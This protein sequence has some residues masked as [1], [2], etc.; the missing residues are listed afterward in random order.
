MKNDAPAQTIPSGARDRM[1]AS[2]HPIFAEQ[3]LTPIFE[4][5]CRHFF[6]P[7]LAANRAWLTMLVECGIVKSKPAKAIFKGLDEVEAAG[8]DAVRPFDP[9]VEYYYLHMERAL[10]GLVLGGEAVVG[11]LNLGRTRPEPLARMVIRE[12]LLHNVGYMDTEEVEL[13]CILPLFD[14]FTSV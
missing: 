5:N 10:V 12:K 13:E 2:A 11:D 1:R 3:I 8:P 4:F 9:A 6:A 14:C 7:L